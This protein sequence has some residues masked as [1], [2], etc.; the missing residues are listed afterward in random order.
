M[1]IA[2]DAAYAPLRLEAPPSF[3]NNE[4]MTKMMRWVTTQFMETKLRILQTRGALT[5]R[6]RLVILI[7][8]WMLLAYG[9]ITHQCLKDAASF[10]A[11][12]ALAIHHMIDIRVI[13]TAV[14]VSLPPDYGAVSDACVTVMKTHG[15]RK[16]NRTAAE[17]EAD[18]VAMAAAVVTPDRS[19]YSREDGY[20]IK[21][22]EG[23]TRLMQELESS[24]KAKYIVSIAVAVVRPEEVR[25]YYVPQ[26]DFP[27]GSLFGRLTKL[28]DS[29]EDQPIPVHL[30]YQC[31]MDVLHEDYVSSFSYNN[32]M[33]HMLR[34]LAIIQVL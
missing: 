27:Y 7:R 8:E 20:V 26:L 11:I 13:C 12:H 32:S 17:I 24:A 28:I 5:P 19:S 2:A 18:I 33:K 34:G 14:Q 3:D 21:S 23:G 9:N 29:G 1:A 22:R 25:D 6:H 31:M 30:V 4:T 15:E 16:G 10:S